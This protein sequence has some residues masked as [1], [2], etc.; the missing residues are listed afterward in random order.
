[1]LVTDPCRECGFAYNLRQAATAGDD[2]RA[3]VAEVVTILCD[4]TIDVRSRPRNGV[5]SPLEY[6]CHLRDVLL[7]QRERVLAARRTNGADCVSMGREDRAVHDGYNEQEP[8]TV[9]RQLADAALLFG[10]VLARLT[11]ADWDRTVVYHYPVT[12][13]RSLRWVA[14]H[15]AHEVQHHLLDI[16]RQI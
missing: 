8:G 13:E 4:N 16:R 15:T 12:A 3:R 6:G 11:T 5:W 1:M 14:V 2:V 7:V 9:A 10:N